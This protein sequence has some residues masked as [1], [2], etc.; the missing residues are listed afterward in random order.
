MT[1]R[2]RVIMRARTEIE[3]TASGRECIVVTEIPYMVNKAEM[4]KKIGD[5]VNEKKIEGISYIND[6]SDRS[7]MRI[8]IFLKHDASANVIL[9][10]LFKNTQ[11]QMSFAV[12]NIALVNGRPMLLNLKDLIHYFVEHR[13]DVVVRRTRFDLNKAEERAHIVAGLVL[14]LANIDEVIAIIKASAD[15]NVACEKLMQAFELSDK[16]ANAILE[17][18]LQRLTGLE[19]DK[20]IQEYRNVIDMI[21]DLLDILDKPERVRQIIEDDLIEIKNEYG[22]DRRSEIDPT[23]DPNFDPRD[24]IPRREMVVTLTRDGY[25]KS[26]QLSDY[27]AQR[28]GG[29]GKKAATMKLFRKRMDENGPYFLENQKREASVVWLC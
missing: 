25:I 14:A 27:Q 29:Q 17:M 28:R 21:A 7:G 6:E 26:Q 4:I 22:D 3:H 1:G 8:T 24:L 23:G 19:Q 5:L 10:T 13:H 11:L 12:N 18:R 16:Q 20:I 2:G 9:N 15:K